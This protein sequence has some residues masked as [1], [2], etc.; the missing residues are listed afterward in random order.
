MK[1]LKTACI[2]IAMIFCILCLSACQESDEARYNR[3]QKLL[4]EGK[5]FEA[6]SLLDGMPTYEDASRLSMYA[7]ALALAENGDYGN[8]ITT[9]RALGDFKDSSLMI[10]YYTGRQYEENAGNPNWSTL[11]TAA[12]Y[13]D[14][15]HYFMDSRSR[16]ENCRK[17]VYEEAVRLAGNGEYGQSAEM[18][19]ALKNYSDSP[20]LKRYYTAFRLEQ[21]NRYKDAAAAFAELGDYRD[22]AEQAEQVL[23]RGFEKADILERAG[24]R[25]EALAIFNDLGDYGEAFERAGKYFYDL[26]LTKREGKDWYGAIQAFESA[27]AYGDAAEQ[28]LETQY[29]Q[30]LYKREQQ[31]W[32][33]AVKLFKDIPEYKDSA[34]QADETRYQQA[35]A[36]EAKGDQEGAYDLFISLGR[37]RDAYDRASKPYYE[38]G[39]ALREAQAWD[40]AIAAFA[41]IR[42]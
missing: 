37:Y 7:K 42:T 17:T 19:G 2:I 40:D 10:T 18:L 28:I 15:V 1:T 38:L 27:G 11:I 36:L 6:T 25:E 30:A 35:D 21:E 16:A 9:F 5:Y 14:M 24:N 8:A 39:I 32:N 33:E 20:D 41:K 29:Q 3:A 4:G 34:M 12:E 22:S 23:Q 13:Y 31:N 26:G